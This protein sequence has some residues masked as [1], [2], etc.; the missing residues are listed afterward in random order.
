MTDVMIDIETFGNGNRACIVQVGGCY[1]DRYTGEI[2]ETFKMNI[3]ATSSVK[4][5]CEIDADTIYWWL[6]R[7]EE[8]IRSITETPRID[9]SGAMVAFNHFLKDAGNVW[10]H[11]TFDFVIVTNTFK[12]LGIKPSFHYRAARDIR[13]LVNLAGTDTY[14]IKRE[15]THHDALADCL[16]Q[17]NYCVEAFNRLTDRHHK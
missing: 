10:S 2:G 16:H 4:A 17:V 9:V 13:T 14:K 8:A 7:S 15:G 1:F 3:D 6:G 12:L 11:A 5:G